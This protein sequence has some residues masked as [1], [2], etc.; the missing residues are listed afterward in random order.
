MLLLVRAM[1]VDSWCRVVDAG[2]GLGKPL[3]GRLLY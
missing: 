2:R 3:K 1:L